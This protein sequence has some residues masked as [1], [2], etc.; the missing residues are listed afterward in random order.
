MSSV[1][2][3]LIIR[4]PPRSTP[5]PYTT[6]FR[7]WDVKDNKVAGNNK[8]CAGEDVPPLSGAGIAL[9]GAQDFR[10]RGNAV[11]DNASPAT[12][13]VKGGIAVL[14]TDSVPPGV[15]APGFDPSG[16]VKHNWA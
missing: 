5:F 13:L 12:S 16:S 2:F 9:V 8:I 11:Y 6:L 3:F 10:V 4:R 7:S 14:S 15:L 1:V